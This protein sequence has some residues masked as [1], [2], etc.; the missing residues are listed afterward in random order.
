MT[1]CNLRDDLRLPCALA[2]RESLSLTKK[3]SRHR[4]I[5]GGTPRAEACSPPCSPLEA[6]IEGGRSTCTLPWRTNTEGTS[7]V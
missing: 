6:L 4:A 2:A 7:D 1:V 3:K 5:E